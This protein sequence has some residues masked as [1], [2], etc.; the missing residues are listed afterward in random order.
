MALFTYFWK[1]GRSLFAFEMPTASR[2][3]AAAIP[4][5]MIVVGWAGVYWLYGK[6][7]AVKG[8]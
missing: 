4:V 2:V 6:S 3:R 7:G 5:V 8:I 1:L